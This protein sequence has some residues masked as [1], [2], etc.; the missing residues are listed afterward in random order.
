MQVPG[1]FSLHHRPYKCEP[2]LFYTHE[3]S[4]TALR[5]L[6]TPL[7]AF[8]LGLGRLDGVL[9]TGYDSTNCKRNRSIRLGSQWVSAPRPPMWLIFWD[10]K[11]RVLAVIPV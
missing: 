2:G 1:T 7:G 10:F 9:R 11:L 4:L 5:D 6:E 3:L 8:V